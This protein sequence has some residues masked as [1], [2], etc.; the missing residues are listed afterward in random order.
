VAHSA[1]NN[2]IISNNEEMFPFLHR[3]RVCLITALSFLVLPRRDASQ[4]GDN[5]LAGHSDVAL[6]S[7]LR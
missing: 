5:Y 4:I 2:A 7:S 3:S 1:A 6:Q